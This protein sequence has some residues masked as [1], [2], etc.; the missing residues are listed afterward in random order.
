LG[1]IAGC[2]ECQRNKTEQHRATDHCDPAVNIDHFGF[3]AAID[4]QLP[5]AQ[6]ARTSRL[7]GHALM[8]THPREGAT[9]ARVSGGA[10]R[11]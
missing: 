3:R 6:P 5:E 1:A 4:A 2:G 7:G 11:T 8:W 9:P 10:P